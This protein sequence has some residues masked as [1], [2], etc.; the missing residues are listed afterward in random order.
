MSYTTVNQNNRLDPDKLCYR[1][2]CSNKSSE[3]IK[4]SAGTFGTITLKL[5]NKCLDFF[6]DSNTSS[7]NQSALQK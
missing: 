7:Q 2:G 5:C 4:V 6:Q 3:K 1:F